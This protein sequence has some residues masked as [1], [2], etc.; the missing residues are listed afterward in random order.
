MQ[1]DD[2]VYAAVFVEDDRKVFARRLHAVEKIVRL[3]GLGDE[4]GVDDRLFFDVLG[5]FIVEAEVNFRIE[6]ARHVVDVLAA[7]GVEGMIALFDG[8]FPDGG[9]VALEEEVDILPVRAHFADVVLLEVEDVLDELVLLLVDGALLAARFRHE[10]DL[11]FGDFLA[12]IFGLD[13]KQ[14]QNAV[15]RHR[16]KP[17][18]GSKQ[19]R[20]E[21]QD[22]RKPARDFFGVAHRDALGHELAEHDGK[23]GKDERDQNEA[24]G[25]EHL[26]AHRKPRVDDGLREGFRKVIRRERTAEERCERDGDLDGGKEARG[27]LREPDD[28]SCSAVPVFGKLFHL[29]LVGGNDCDLRTREDGVE[30][31]EYD[32]QDKGY[33]YVAGVHGVSFA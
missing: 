30:G 3:H 18:E 11:F 4:H 6:H 22:A 1:R 31:D 25:L 27:V 14:A 29:G 9:I 13:A 24:D 15:R 19:H 12:L 21:A 20:N 33:G 8:L 2:A 28:A 17:Y 32:L 5:R 23:V 7:D 16:Q 26:K 10:H